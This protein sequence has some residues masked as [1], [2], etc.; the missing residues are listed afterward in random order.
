MASP[1]QS[2][3]ET[4]AGIIARRPVLG[5]V[6][7]AF[8]PLLAAK[9]AIPA[10]LTPGFPLPEW[11]AERA[12][13]GVPLLE[14]ISLAGLGKPLG[15]AAAHMLPLLEA[16]AVVRPHIGALRDI[17]TGPSLVPL[18]EALI[19]ADASALGKAGVP[20]G[21]LAFALGFIVGP[22]LRAVVLARH[23]EPW[24]VEGAWMQGY[25]PVCGSAPSIAFLERPVADEKNAYLK[26]GGGKKHMHCPLCGTDWIFRRGACPSCGEE[27]P[28]VMEML[29]DTKDARGERLDWCTKCRVYCPTV[30]LRER[31]DTPDPDAMAI[32]LLHLDMVAKGKNLRPINPSFWNTFE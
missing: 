16:Q 23:A 5:P 13:E 22:V 24:N 2:V 30:D 28:G 14:G 25:C 8:E 32:G 3:A 7:K 15:A 10:L 6:L 17:F 12:A 11:R 1:C 27:G 4:I 29:R 18:A 26:G 31:D 19:S 21:V 20:P 9:A